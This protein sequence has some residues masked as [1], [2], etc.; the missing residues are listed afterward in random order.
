MYSML[1]VILLGMCILF[2]QYEL[3]INIYRSAAVHVAIKIMKHHAHNI[4]TNSS[5]RRNMNPPFLIIK[6]QDCL[7]KLPTYSASVV[8][9]A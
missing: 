6:N 4:T 9:Q 3:V 7:S 2:Y 8:S 1:P 5:P